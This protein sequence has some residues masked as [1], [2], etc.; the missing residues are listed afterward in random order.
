MLGVTD[1]WRLSY[2]LR[3]LLGTGLAALVLMLPAFL[4]AAFVLGPPFCALG[5]VGALFGQTLLSGRPEHR[6]RD[7][8]LVLLLGLPVLVLGAVVGVLS[9]LL[10]TLLASLYISLL[11]FRCFPQRLMVR[12]SCLSPPSPSGGRGAPDDSSGA[13]PVWRGRGRGGPVR[14]VPRRRLLPGRPVSAGGGAVG[15]AGGG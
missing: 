1:L 4:Y 14:A 5:F 2:L 12:R 10:S 15:A 3:M 13:G 7:L 8:S 6:L 11:V 9:L